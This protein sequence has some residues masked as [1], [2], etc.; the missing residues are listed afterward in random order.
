MGELLPRVN[1]PMV[2]DAF[3][4]QADAEERES[5]EVTIAGELESEEGTNSGLMIT[6][7]KEGPLEGPSEVCK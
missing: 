6:G 3:R 5:G 1:E 7:D 2:A 4:T